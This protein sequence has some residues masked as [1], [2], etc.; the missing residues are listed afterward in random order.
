MSSSFLAL[1]KIPVFSGLNAHELTR[2]GNLARI[3]KA[4]KNQLVFQ[5]QTAGSHLFVVLNGKIKIFSELAPVGKKKAFAYLE[6]GDFFGEM[7]LL[8]SKGRSLSAVALENTELL[9][10]S[11]A[12][13]QRL[14]AKDSKFML[15]I[16]QTLCERLRHANDE[17]ESLTFRSLY[18]RVCGKLLDL[19][20]SEVTKNGG[21]RQIINVTHNELAEFIGTAREMV[22]KVLSSLRK[23]SVIE[24]EDRKITILSLPKLKELA[25][26]NLGE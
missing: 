13:F 6:R 19:A 2:L 11:R 18:G 5:K 4:E 16:L 10:I 22:T 15:K 12:E 14:L 25:Q 8:D 23:L 21:T 3:H 9:T 17:I 7:S 26:V 24:S 1:K 20:Q